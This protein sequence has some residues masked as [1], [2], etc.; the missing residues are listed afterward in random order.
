VGVPSSS[1]ATATVGALSGGGALSEA[2]KMADAGAAMQAANKQFEQDAKEMEK[3][4]MPT[5]LRVQFM[6]FDTEDEGE[7]EEDES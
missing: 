1:E 3:T 4:F 2:G 5:W 7:S 6:G